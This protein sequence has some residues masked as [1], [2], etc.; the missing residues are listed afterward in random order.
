MPALSVEQFRETQNGR[1]RQLPPEA[2]PPFDFHGY[3]D[4]IPE[5]DLEGYGIDGSVTHVYEDGQGRYQHVLYNTADAN[6][7]MVVVLDVARGQVHGHHL[8]HL[9]RL[10]GLV[11]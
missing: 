8:L 9:N 7:F 5:S 3:V 1:M 2:E 10:Y 11:S 4:T 6:V